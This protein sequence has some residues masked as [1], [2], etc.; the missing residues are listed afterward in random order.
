MATG[1]PTAWRWTR[2]GRE[3]MR[4]T[5]RRALAGLGLGIASGAVA[6]AAGARL[7]LGAGQDGPL[8]G[9]WTPL[10]ELPW[11]WAS[12]GWLGVANQHRPRLDL[13]FAARPLSIGGTGFERGI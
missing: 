12:S 11:Q 3:L 6:G 1:P 4:L 9:Q 8:A 2:P 5:R 7:A 10:G 13:S